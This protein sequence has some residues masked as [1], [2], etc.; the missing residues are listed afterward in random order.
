[1]PEKGEDIKQRIIPF[2]MNVRQVHDL[3]LSYQ[4]IGGNLIEQE[5][6]KSVSAHAQVNATIQSFAGTMESLQSICKEL[7][8]LMVKQP[9]LKGHIQSSLTNRLL[10]TDYVKFTKSNLNDIIILNNRIISH[11]N[12]VKKRVLLTNDF[13]GLVLT[14]Q[15][16][17]LLPLMVNYKDQSILNLYFTYIQAY[18][19]FMNHAVPR[20]AYHQYISILGEITNSVKKINSAQSMSLLY[21]IYWDLLLF[22]KYFDK[23]PAD[24]ETCKLVKTMLYTII[25]AARTLLDSIQLDINSSNNSAEKLKVHMDRIKKF[26]WGKDIQLW[27]MNWTIKRFQKIREQSELAGIID[28]YFTTSQRTELISKLN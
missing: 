28:G 8:K 1:M 14:Q 25:V 9:D 17:H 3:L 11:F 18:K 12:L 23:R 10:H 6:V 16:H 13:Q 26:F 27:V 19:D 7:L 20:L 24:E 21:M 22:L 5:D 15:L 4:R 2:N